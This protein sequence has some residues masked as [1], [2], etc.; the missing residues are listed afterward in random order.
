MSKS[1]NSYSSMSK[2][3][4]KTVLED[5]YIKQK[6]SFAD[7][8]DKFDTYANKVRRD[9]KAFNIPIRDKSDA[10]KNALNTGKHK[11][12]T[13]GQ[14]RPD[15]I[16]NKIGVSVMKSWDSLSEQEIEKRKTKA[17][18][19]WD[20]MSEDQKNNML[21]LAND[22]VRKTSKVGSKLEKYLFNNLITDGYRIEFHKEQ[23]LSNTKLQIDLFV[24][25][26]ETAIEIDGPSHF[27]PVWGEDSL[28]RNISYDNKK[29][30][31]IIGRGW[32]L[33]RVKQTKDFSKS[34]ANLIYSKLKE[35]L[36]QLSDDK[37]NKTTSGTKTFTIEDND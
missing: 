9:A 6:L 25:N 13:K 11:H 14:V 28:K 1:V 21:K 31:L 2:I 16:K 32:N 12:P 7:I 19:N 35:I 33:I 10:Q 26:I 27:L 3:E 22:A 4:K 37:K 20:S 23:T 30:G 8:A 24:S 34:R 17:K 18:E 29:E 15:N 5:L 36:V